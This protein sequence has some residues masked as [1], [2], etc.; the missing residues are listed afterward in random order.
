MTTLSRG[1]NGLK[2]PYF[3]FVIIRF[4][5]QDFAGDEE[6]LVQLLMPLLAQDWPG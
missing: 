4:G 1:S 6:F 5:F 2:L 3:D